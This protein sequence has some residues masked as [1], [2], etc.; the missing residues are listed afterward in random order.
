VFITSRTQHGILL[1]AKLTMG[2]RNF[3]VR[4]NQIKKA[5][6]GGGGG[7]VLIRSFDL[8]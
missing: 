4:R 6:G 1:G 8:Y 2:V 7:L 3:N 5:G